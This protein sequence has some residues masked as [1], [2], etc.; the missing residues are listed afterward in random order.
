MVTARTDHV[1]QQVLGLLPADQCGPGS[2]D[3]CEGTVPDFGESREVPSC[4]DEAF[5]RDG[6][7]DNN[8]CDAFYVG[9]T[10]NT[11]FRDQPV[12]F[13]HHPNAKIAMR[14]RDER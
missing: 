13:G 11:D 5:A 9:G 8:V 6:K 14:D 4:L 3:P 10:H 7:V 2:F 12:A 1:K